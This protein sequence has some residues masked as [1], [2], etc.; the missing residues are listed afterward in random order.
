M[1]QSFQGIG[2]LG[3]SVGIISFAENAIEWKDR[4]NA[5]V[6]EIPKAEIGGMSWAVYG[7][8]AHLKVALTSK[9]GALRFDG[10]AATDFELISNLCKKHYSTSVVKDVVSMQSSIYIYIYIYIYVH[11]YVLYVHAPSTFVTILRYH[12]A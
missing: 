12:T 1:V 6:K 2:L 10:F 9:S 5:A 4:S 8:R 3:H 11:I 7:G